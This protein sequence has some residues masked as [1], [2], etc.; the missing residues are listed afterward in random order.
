MAASLEAFGELG[1]NGASM[2]EI[3]NRAGTSLSN[4]YNY[5]PGKAELLAHVL[6]AANDDLLAHLTKAVD[7]A[8]SPGERLEAAARSYVLWGIQHQTEGIVAISEFRYLTGDQRKEVVAARDQTERVFV[9]A[10]Q[11]GVASGEFG[12]PHPRQ[13][14]RSVALLCASVPN[15]YRG[16]GASTPEE[17]ADGQ[18]RL[19]LA[20]VEA[21]ALD[22]ARRA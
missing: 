2:R 10:V 7:V 12:T 3:A 20:I 11:A 5:V 18:A 17:V 6:R 4:L 16:D 22:R 19:A 13:A 1:F 14:A 9:D 15:W 8:T 21:T